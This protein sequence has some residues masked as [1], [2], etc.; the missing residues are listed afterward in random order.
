MEESAVFRKSASECYKQEI[1]RT[2]FSVIKKVGFELFKERNIRSIV[3]F[4]SFANPMEFVPGISD[5]DVIYILGRKIYV[6]FRDR[7]DLAILM[8]REIDKVGLPRILRVEPDFR[9]Y[10]ETRSLYLRGYPLGVMTVRSP[11]RIYDDGF[12]KRLERK[13]YTVS[14]NA[15][16]FLIRSAI[17]ALGIAY[18][19][20]FD[21]NFA[22]AMNNA[23]HAVR[24]ACRALIGK[25]LNVMPISYR[26]VIAGLK[27]LKF[28]KLAQQYSKTFGERMR[29]MEVGDRSEDFYRER[30]WIFP[31]NAPLKSVLSAPDPVLKYILV[32]EDLT[33]E[34]LKL[35]GTSKVIGFKDLVR[36]LGCQKVSYISASA[37]GNTVLWHLEC[38]DRLLVVD[39]FTGAIMNRV[40]LRR[41]WDSRSSL[42]ASL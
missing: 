9:Y 32:A 35:T 29:A 42:S 18:N 27:R 19:K 4:G 33:K 5:I 16:R 28:E 36:I 24:H 40:R 39:A 26:E 37:F 3:V 11:L 14:K 17:V 31:F 22:P 20:Y 7:I 21:G 1:V 23:Y 41:R 34:I 13:S 12:L 25:N 2:L 8:D 10:D 38:D 15:V 30:G 6:D